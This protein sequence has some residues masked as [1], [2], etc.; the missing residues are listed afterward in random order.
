ML[1]IVADSMWQMPGGSK[2]YGPYTG[3]YSSC[4]QSLS[5]YCVVDARSACSGAGSVHA[6][7]KL[8]A[9]NDSSLLSMHVS[10]AGLG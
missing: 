10:E 1:D 4:V 7:R 5:V 6:T 8:R 2:L 9:R 3:P